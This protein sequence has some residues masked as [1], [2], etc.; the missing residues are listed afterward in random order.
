MNVL[1][2]TKFIVL[3]VICAFGSILN[4]ASAQQVSAEGPQTTQTTRITDPVT[5][6]ATK[7]PLRAF[8]FPGMVSLITNSQAQ[9][10]QSST[11]DDVLKLIPNLQF[12]RGPRRTGEE[13]SIR[14]VSGPDVIILLDG[15]RQNF[16]SAHDG[17]FFVD[18]SFT[19]EAEVLK[20]PASALYGSGGLGGVIEFRTLTPSDLLKDE[21]KTAVRFSAGY[22]DVNNERSATIIGAVRATEQI[23]F[24]AGVTKRSSGS[25]ELGNETNLSNTEDEI[26][27]ALFKTEVKLDRFHSLGA[28]ISSFNNDAEEPSNGQGLGG[29]DRTNKDIYSNT[30]SVKY[31]YKNPSNKL[32]D[33]DFFK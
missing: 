17:R 23:D 25:I 24:I 20:G 11:I 32:F 26:I 27:N 14:G 12:S 3:F 15:A 10:D 7:N 21:D 28:S 22:Q 8:D 2:V 6:T 31:A 4:N 33:I 30:L 18:P 9:F 19:K 5:I 16:G 1:V 29:D 13:P